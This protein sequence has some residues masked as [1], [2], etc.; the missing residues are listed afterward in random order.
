[1][2][3]KTAIAALALVLGLPAQAVQLPSDPSRPLILNF[4]F[5]EFS[6]TPPYGSVAFRLSYETS[7]TPTTIHFVWF[8][9]LDGS[10]S[11]YDV[12]LPLDFYTAFSY[13]GFSAGWTGLTD[14]TFSMGLYDPTGLASVTDFQAMGVR[15]VAG[16]RL[17][18]PVIAHSLTPVPEPTSAAL[19]LAGLAGLAWR[20][21]ALRG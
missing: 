18:T 19:L 2:S 10:G 16:Q 5:T 17:T 4:D 8:D 11:S 12:T 14:G 20:R 6:P 7:G 21:R 15:S 9:G 1:M 13:P 3:L